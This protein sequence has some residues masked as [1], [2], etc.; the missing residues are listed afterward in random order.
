MTQQNPVTAFHFPGLEG[1]LH[2]VRVITLGQKPWFVTVDVAHALGMSAAKGANRLCSHLGGD[3]V[4][5]LRLVEAIRGNPNKSVISESG[6]YK[7]IMR[8]DKKQAKAFQNW[9]TKAVLPAIRQDGMYLMDEEKVASGEVSMEAIKTMLEEALEKKL[10]RLAEAAKGNTS[11]PT[12]RPPHAIRARAFAENKLGTQDIL[13][14]IVDD[15]AKKATAYSIDHQ[16]PVWSEKYGYGAKDKVIN[17][18]LPEALEAVWAELEA[19][20]KALFG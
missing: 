18:Y 19:K 3:E 14:G 4:K 8:S 1:V 17:F 2:K 13:S 15:L 6:L 20:V 12:E 7:L 9:V 5:T 10:G 11:G 16:L